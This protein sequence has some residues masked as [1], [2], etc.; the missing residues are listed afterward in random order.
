MKDQGHCGACW[1]FAAIGALEGA[2]FAKTG[3]LQ[4]F[5][6]QQLIDCN[7]RKN[8]KDKKGDHNK[9]CSGG[10]M[11]RAFKYFQDYSPMLE[12]KYPYT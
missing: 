4:S 11:I 8:D 12:S 9:G 10:D 1:A 3:K 6:V 5:S 7:T 2:N